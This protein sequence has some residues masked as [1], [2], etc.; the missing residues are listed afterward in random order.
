MFRNRTEGGDY[1]KLGRG[2]IWHGEIP[3]CLHQNHVFVVRPHAKLLSYFL[4]A[5]TSSDY[6]RA[7]FQ[8]CS[9]QSTNLASINSSQL[10]AFPVP[11][12]P[13]HEQQAITSKLSI[14]DRAIHLLNGLI[15]GNSA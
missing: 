14:W 6:G 10:K 13:I 7:Y 11:L 2:F 5:L 15:A 4:A 9:K 1:D 3:N 8:A 12:P